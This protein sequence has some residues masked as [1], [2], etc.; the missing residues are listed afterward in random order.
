MDGSIQGTSHGMTSLLRRSGHGRRRAHLDRGDVRPLLVVAAAAVA[1]GAPVRAAAI[2]AAAALR[3]PL[4]LAPLGRARGGLLRLPRRALEPDLFKLSLARLLLCFFLDAVES[5]KLDTSRIAVRV[6]VAAARE[7][8]RAG[9]AAGSASGVA[10]RRGVACARASA[11]HKPAAC[12]CVAAHD[13]VHLVHLMPA[14]ARARERA[15]LE[16]GRGGTARFLASVARTLRP[17]AS[18]G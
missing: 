5:L 18:A 16:A 17:C 1:R 13:V 8:R 2:A 15:A 3:L 4:L 9:R 12:A 6:E 14:R 10:H 7:A 11:W